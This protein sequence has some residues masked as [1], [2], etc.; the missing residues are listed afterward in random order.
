MAELLALH[1]R[2]MGTTWSARLLPPPGVDADALA[3]GIQ[4]MLDRVDAQ[5]STWRPDSALCRFNRAPAGSWRT[6]P[7]EFHTVLRHAL[8]V[9]EASD[10]AY[11]P[12]VGALVSLWGFGPA[13]RPAQAPPAAQIDALRAQLGW[14][15]LQCDDTARAVRQPGGVSLDLSSVAKGYAV[16]LAGAWLD[17]AGASSW[18]LEVGGE[19][20][21]R[22]A[23][24]DGTPWRVGIERPDGSGALIHA[25]AL[26][27][28][29]IASSG[30]YRRGYAEGGAY[31]SHH[32][33]PRLGR[34]VPNTVA[35]VSVLAEHALHADPIGT[36]L[37]VLGV[38][39]GLAFAQRQNLAVLVMEHDGVGGFREHRTPGFEAAVLA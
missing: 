12:T 4:A 39:E 24:P 6:L 27:G 34:P 2:S 19:L 20:K 22:G 28:R 33:D 37:S 25:V 9:A 8:R 23:K 32:V 16:D 18:L 21:A 29:A 17:E 11:D 13:P 38:A 10:G 15:R 31:L 7:V 35:A 1:G 5:M 36:T 14:W 3:Q 26:D 30:G